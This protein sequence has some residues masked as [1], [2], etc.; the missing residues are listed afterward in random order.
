VPVGSRVRASAQILSVED[1]PGG[2]QLTNLI[3]IEREG[4]D[5]PC[6]VVESISRYIASS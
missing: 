3:T 6:C 1:V 2:V 4:V 5:K